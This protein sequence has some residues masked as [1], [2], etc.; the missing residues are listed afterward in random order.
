MTRAREISNVLGRNI[1]STTFTA[2]AGQTAF[3]I[4]HATGRIQVYMNGLLLDPTVDWTSDG[5]TVTLTEGA[6]AGDE[7]EVVKFDTLAVADVVPATGGTFTG[8]VEVE[9]AQGDTLGAAV[10]VKGSGSYDAVIEVENTTATHGGRGF[11]LATDNTW[12]IGANQ[13]AIG[14]GSPSSSNTAIAIDS[15]NRVTTPSR[16]AFDVALDGSNYTTANPVIFDE[17]YH[18]VGSHYSTTTGRFT[19][20]VAGMYLFYTS[21]IKNG[22]TAVSRRRFNKNGSATKGSRHQR[23]TETSINTY[24]DNGTFFITI[25]CAAGDYITV[26][27]YAGSVYGSREYDY[28]GGYL[29]G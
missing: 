9:N 8:N 26:E 18:N 23:L 7:L 3:S 22:S 6:A 12:S 5:S 21:H 14:Y 28:F 29:I 10:S 11:L 27:Q 13:V 2:T 4:T 20:P 24:G 1:E 19:C 17:V 16:P 25:E 15:S